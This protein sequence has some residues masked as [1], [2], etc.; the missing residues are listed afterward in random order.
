MPM[1]TIHRQCL[2]TRQAHAS[3]LATAGRRRQHINRSVIRCAAATAPSKAVV[4]DQVEIGKSGIMVSSLAI[5]AWQFGDISFWGYST[6]G[7]YGEDQIRQAYR[8]IVESGLNF[9][10]TA[11]VYGRGGS[12]QF[13]RDF[14][15]QTGKPVKIATKFAPL[16]WR[17][18]EQNVIKACKGSLERLGLQQMELYQQHWPG[19]PVVNSWANDAFYRGLAQCQKQGL[20]KAVG[21]SNHNEKRLKRAFQ[22]MQGNG[23]RL[24]SNQVQFSLLYRRFEKDGMLEAAKELGVS[25]IAY[26]PLTQGLLAGN[27]KPGG[28]KP[29]GPRGALFSDD[30]LRDVQPLVELLRDIGQ[31][32]GKKPAQVAVN[33]NICKGTIPIVGVKSYQ[34]AV[35]AAGALGWR[36]SADEV[37]ALDKESDKSKAQ[38]LGAPFENW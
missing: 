16:P 27:Y 18:G 14:A 17:F 21:V 23:V 9:V 33:W 20:T 28:S 37:A 11:E 2:G 31:S 24:A 36:L 26:S 13:L 35:D 22:V 3:S 4:E 29:G 12:E 32:H 30:K 7:G 8:G 25:I 1:S 34:Q 6:Y 15:R 38:G 19:F 10:D 5:G